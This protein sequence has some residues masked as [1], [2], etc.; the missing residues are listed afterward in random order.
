MRHVDNGAL[1]DARALAPHVR[2]D[3]ADF[4]FDLSEKA[5]RTPHAG[6]MTEARAEDA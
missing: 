3:Y 6:G 1:P 4:H 5:A 2:A